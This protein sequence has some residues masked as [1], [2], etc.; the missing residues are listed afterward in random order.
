[1]ISYAIIG[2]SFNKNLHSSL[3]KLISQIIPIMIEKFSLQMKNDSIL[4][5]S[6]QLLFKDRSDTEGIK[7]GVFFEC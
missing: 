4:L 7:R 5:S 6:K 2:F 1:M 3:K